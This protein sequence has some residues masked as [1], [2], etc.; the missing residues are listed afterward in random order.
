MLY[1]RRRWRRRSTPDIRRPQQL[2]TTPSPARH[3]AKSSDSSSLRSKSKTRLRRAAA[4]SLREFWQVDGA[5]CCD[6]IALASHLP[7]QDEAVARGLSLFA[8]TRR[9]VV[10]EGI[11][12]RI[13]GLRRRAETTLGR[14]EGGFEG[15]KGEVLG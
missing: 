7:L 14:L 2:A 1:E 11:R 12:L 6:A 13:A 4:R 10:M 5:V 15:L 8:T 3:C 9:H